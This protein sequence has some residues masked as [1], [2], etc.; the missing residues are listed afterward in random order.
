MVSLHGELWRAHSA[1]D[2]PLVPGS[3]VRVEEIE[4]G[5]RLVVGSPLAPI[6]EEPV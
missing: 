5:L 4:P 3:R 2:E 1:D 6:E